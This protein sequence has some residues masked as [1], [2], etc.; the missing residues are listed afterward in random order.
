MNKKELY[1][2]SVKGIGNLYLEYVFNEY[3]GEPILFVL[4]DDEMK[5]YLALCYEIRYSL[6]WII[7]DISKDVIKQ[8]LDRTLTLYDAFHLKDSNLKIV[9]KNN[10][11]K[12]DNLPTTE[13]DDLTYP[14]K[15]LTLL[16]DF[17]DAKKYFSLC[18]ASF[19]FNDNLSIDSLYSNIETLDNLSI[20]RVVLKSA[21]AD[22][23]NVQK[24][25][26]LI[27]VA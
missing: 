13:I 3:D 25:R 19:Y 9:F 5:Y 20:N 15:S 1:F 18:E 23:E 6:E 12:Y 7:I 17:E 16:C 22:K 26:K 10:E 2:K 24:N 14:E 27:A 4:S 8:L 21:Y 11:W